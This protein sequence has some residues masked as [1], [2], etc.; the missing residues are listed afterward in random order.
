MGCTHRAWHGAGRARQ[1]TGAPPCSRERPPGLARLR[2][3]G[4]IADQRRDGRVGLRRTLGKR[5]YRKVPWVRIPLSPPLSLP[6]QRL[7]AR[8]RAQPEK[9]PRFRGV[10]AVKP[11]RIRTGDCEFRAQ[12]SRG[13]RLS[14]LPSWAVR[15]RS[16]FAPQG[17]LEVRIPFAPPTSPRFHPSLGEARGGGEDSRDSAGFW[18][19]PQG[20]SNR[21][22]RG[23]GDPAAPAGCFLRG[24]LG[25]FGFSQPLEGWRRP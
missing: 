3:S 6:L 10:L 23:R 1:R 15:I 17:I 2:T 20:H 12:K 13:P 11:S 8:T 21:R 22:L 4:R 24:R 5:V 9:S 7:P 16:R 25:R 18:A 19:R 14:L